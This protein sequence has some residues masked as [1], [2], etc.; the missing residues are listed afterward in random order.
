MHENEIQHNS[1]SKIANTATELKVAAHTSH[2]WRSMRSVERESIDMILH[3]I[4]KLTNI[5]TGYPYTDRYD[6][7][8]NI[9][10]F[11]NLMNDF[12]KRQVESQK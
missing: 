11:A 9:V 12:V 10:Y 6:A 5:P 7:T 4:A 1:F 3:E 2:S 8:R